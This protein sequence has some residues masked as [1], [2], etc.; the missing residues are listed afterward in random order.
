[1]ADY[2]L[3]ARGTY[4]GSSFNR[5]VAQSGNQLDTFKGKCTAI[6]VAIGNLMSAAV[7]KV[8]SAISGSLDSAISRVDTMNNFSKVM[9]NMGISADDANEA[10]RTLSGDALKG[11]PTTLDSAV[12]GDRKSVV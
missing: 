11:L 8:G 2:T 6:S 7:Q 4:D 3:S 1:M 5:G 10:I 9:S 12:A